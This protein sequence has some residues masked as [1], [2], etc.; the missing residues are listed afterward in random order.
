MKTPIAKE[1]SDQ[2]DSAL[3]F[4]DIQEQSVKVAI[5]HVQTAMATAISNAKE[6]TRADHNKEAIAHAT[7]TTKAKRV[8]T[9]RIMVAIRA[10]ADTKAVV[11]TTTNVEDT[12]TTEADITTTEAVDTTTEAVDTTNME[13]TTTIVAATDNKVAIANTAATTTQMQSIRSKSA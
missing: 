6:A 7:T 8:D 12:T 2:R 1:D 13:D 9:S 11:D 3:I 4:R 5:A 10:V